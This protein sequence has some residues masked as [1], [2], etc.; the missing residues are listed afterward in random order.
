[1]ALINAALVNI[2]RRSPLQY[3]LASLLIGPFLTL[4]LAGTR[5]DDAGALRQV[6]LWS[7]RAG[8]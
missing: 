1:L 6:D 5:E 8:K 4:L 7:G 3:F 2:D